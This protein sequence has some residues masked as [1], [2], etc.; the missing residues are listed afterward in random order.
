MGRVAALVF[1]VVCLGLL[2]YDGQLVLNRLAGASNLHE[3]NLWKVALAAV[4]QLFAIGFAAWYAFLLIRAEHSSS[5]FA[6]NVSLKFRLLPFVL[7]ML[8]SMASATLLEIG[9]FCG[10]QSF[11]SV[12]GRSVCPSPESVSGR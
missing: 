8:M 11:P 2:A 5:P 3:V 1:L 4:V 10:E 9:L 6:R 7:P 12:R